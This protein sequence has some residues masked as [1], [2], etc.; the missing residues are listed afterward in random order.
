MKNKILLNSLSFWGTLFLFALS[1]T[2]NT[3]FAY[4]TEAD[5]E[6][7]EGAGQCCRASDGTY[8]KKAACECYAA[9]K[10]GNVVANNQWIDYL[11]KEL[12]F[13]KAKLGPIQQEIA[14]KKS[15][16]SAQTLLTK[17][18]SDVEEP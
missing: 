1:F 17:A 12:A 8:H 7:S 4:R 14:T 9:A 18:K 2:P 5:C 11:K 10:S 3:A 6:E 13:Y 16:I 15:S